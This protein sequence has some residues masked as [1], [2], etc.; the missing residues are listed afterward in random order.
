MIS[1]TATIGLK[2]ANI[3]QKIVKLEYQNP[4]LT[5]EEEKKLRQLKRAELNLRQNYHIDLED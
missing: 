5:K 2:L 3:Q 1:H 4:I